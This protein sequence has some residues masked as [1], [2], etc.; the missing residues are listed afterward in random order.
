VLTLARAPWLATL[1]WPMLPVLL[2]LAASAQ[3][4]GSRQVGVW[5]RAGPVVKPHAGVPANP[6]LLVTA[7]ERFRRLQSAWD[8]ADVATLRE[9]TTPS[10]FSELVALLP[11]CG[12]GEPNRTDVLALEAHLLAH[13]RIG[14]LELASIEFSGVIREGGDVAAMPFREVWML[15]RSATDAADG[16]RLARQQALL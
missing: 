2:A 10:M 7:Q 3:W 6:A 9:L 16:W 8:R 1:V 15:T 5:R 13:E 12:D 4:W 11:Q 14:P